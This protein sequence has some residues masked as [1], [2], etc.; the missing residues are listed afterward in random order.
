MTTTKPFDISKRLVW[1][2]YKRVKANAG[3]AGV[4][5][6]SLEDFD[7]SLSNNL[8]RIWNRMASGS[9]FPSPVKA[10][11]IPKKAGGQRI[12]GIPTVADRIAQ[13]V[14]KMVLEPQ[15]EPHFHADSYGYRPGK[16]AHQA[17]AVTRQRCWRHAWVLEFD[18]RGLFDNIEHGLLM[19]AVRHHT[20]CRWVL[21]YTQRWL[22]A[23]MQREDGSLDNRHKGTPQG[24]PLSPLLANLFL[25]YAFDRWMSTHHSDV[26]FCRYADDG[27]LHC[28]TESHARYLQNQ[29]AQRLG[30]CGL[31]L[32]PDKTRVVYCKDQHRKMEH[33]VIQFDF[34]G[35][36]FR[37]RRANDRN[38]QVFIGFAPALSGTA[39]K[40]MRQTIR[41]WKLQLKSDKSIEDL[42]YMF[43]P[44]IQGWIGY[45]CRFYRS[46][47]RAVAH[48]L[49]H[50]LVRWAMRKFK[51]FRGHQTRAWQWLAE[52]AK[53][54]PGLFPHWRAGFVPYAGPMGAR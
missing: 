24:G 38:G 5:R 51:R 35:Y 14:V 30:E 47:F 13:T 16:S 20:D 27:V 10:V 37:P 12:L 7:R 11:S 21:L 54:R 25:H 40:S 23:P 8:Y 45:Y 17:L 19:K 50:A 52:Q 2:A 36:N 29:V 49:D 15:L 46:A 4:D 28:R 41:S 18:I 39:A 31:E 48:H 1:E 3:A 43:G 33:E 44:R 42:A 22:T 34:L 32:H 26:P 9:Y 6:Q 53:R